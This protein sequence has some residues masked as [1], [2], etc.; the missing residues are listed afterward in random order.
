MVDTTSVIAI[1]FYFGLGCV[2]IP[3]M[4]FI[5]KVI[6]LRRDEVQSGIDE[7]NEITLS[8]KEVSASVVKNIKSVN[9]RAAEMVSAAYKEADEISLASEQGLQEYIMYQLDRSIMTV[10]LKIGVALQERVNCAID[11]AGEITTE[12]LRKELSKNID[13]RNSILEDF[14]EKARE[15]ICELPS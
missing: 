4:N 8:G 3:S 14:L 5:R 15:K 2:L 6:A 7:I 12:I 10:N 1:A 9:E 11:I 13:L